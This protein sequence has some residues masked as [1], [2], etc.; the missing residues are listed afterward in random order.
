MGDDLFEQNVNNFT[1]HKPKPGQ[2]DVYEELRDKGRELAD[3]IAAQCPPSRERSLRG[4]YVGK[5]F[6]CEELMPS[7][8]LFNN[9]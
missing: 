1:Y 5:C 8:S 9:L 4:Y 2:N 3:K 7:G 6:Y